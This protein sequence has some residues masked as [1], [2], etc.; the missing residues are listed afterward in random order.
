M[1]KLPIVLLDPI[2]AIGPELRTK[3]IT[4]PHAFIEQQL[5]VTIDPKFIIKHLKN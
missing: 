5:G 2:I 1:K 3:K 4:I